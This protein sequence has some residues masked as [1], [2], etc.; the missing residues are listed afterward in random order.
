M[1]PVRWNPSGAIS[2]LNGSLAPPTMSPK[3]HEFV[4]AR[5]VR[6]VAGAPPRYRVVHL[7]SDR[8]VTAFLA[9]LG[10]PSG[11]A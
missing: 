2:P 7:R 4:C 3:A 5:M 10:A 9:T 8:E 1:A 6:L 11:L